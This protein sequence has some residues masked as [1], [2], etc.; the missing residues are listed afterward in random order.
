MEIKASILDYLG[1]FEG[2]IMVLVSLMCD[3]VYHEG[4]FFYTADQMVLNVD[5]LV[6]QKLGCA[7]EDWSGYPDL[8]KS[9]LKTLVPYKE[10]ITRID[11]VDFN[12]FLGA[13]IINSY[14]E[15]YSSHVFCCQKLPPQLIII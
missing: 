14:N 12:Q 5:E 15:V 8:L 10:M 2:G 4:V 9:I 3:G 11:D 13:N 6:E 1:K 7:I